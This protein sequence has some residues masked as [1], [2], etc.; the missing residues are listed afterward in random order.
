[1]NIYGDS[2]YQ[3]K[4]KDIFMISVLLKRMCIVGVMAVLCVIGLEAKG[5][6]SK[7]ASVRR[8][9]LGNSG[10]DA[11]FVRFRDCLERIISEKLHEVERELEKEFCDRNEFIVNNIRALNIRLQE[12]LACELAASNAALES[13][14]ACNL[15][16]VETEVEEFIVHT[17]DC[18]QSLICQQL[19]DLDADIDQIICKLH[20]G[21]EGSFCLVSGL[22]SFIEILS[23]TNTEPILNPYLG[24]FDAAL[25]DYLCLEANHDY[26]P[27]DVCSDV[28]CAIC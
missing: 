1:M 9:P 11:D 22:I 6:K 26:I 12:F 15:D 16:R 17:I 28:P 27:V 20:S 7:N 10:C 8:L 18:I 21:I 2:F 13:F 3:E 5:S 24:A 4:K 25:A 14:F 23:G 19:T